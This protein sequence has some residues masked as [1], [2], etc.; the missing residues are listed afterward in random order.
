MEIQNYQRE[1]N[2]LISNG[3]Y[4][5]TFKVTDD[6]LASHAGIL[7]LELAGARRPVFT[8]TPR[9]FYNAWC[10]SSGQQTACRLGSSA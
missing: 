2:R 3:L 8:T 6:W 7:P 1:N 4:T 10:R 9:R 5:T